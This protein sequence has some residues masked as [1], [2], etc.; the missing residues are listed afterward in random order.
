MQR[1]FSRGLSG[2]V[3]EIEPKRL[4]PTVENKAGT[5]LEVKR[6]GVG[7]LPAGAYGL[8]YVFFSPDG[9]KTFIDTAGEGGMTMLA[10]VAY[11]Y[12]AS[13]WRATKM[14]EAPLMVTEEDQ[15]T[16]MDSW[17]ADHDLAEVLAQPSPDFDMGEMLEITSHYLDNTGGC[18]WVMDK[19]SQ[20]IPRRMMPFS[21][22]EFLPQRGIDIDTGQPRL[23]ANFIVQTMEGPQ[24]KQARDVCF[25]RDTTGGTGFSIGGQGVSAWGRGRC[26][27]DIAMSWLALG[28]KAQN[29]IRALMANSVWPSI[30]VSPDKD[31]EPSKDDLDRYKDDLRKYGRNKQGEPFVALGGAAVTQIAS[32]LKDLVP[33]EVLDRVESVVA[34]VSGVPAI[35]LQ[36]EVGL[37]NAPWSHMVQARR[38]A[39]EDTIAPGWRRLERVITKQILRPMDDDPTHHIKFDK[40]TVD[41]LKRDQ[42]ES[43]QI[44]TMMGDQASLNERR[45]VMGLEPSDDPKADDIPELTKPSILDVLAAQ[46]PKPL[47]D[48]GNAPPPKGPGTGA[49]AENGPPDPKARRNALELKFKGPA[50]VNAFRHE[51]IPAWKITA[52]GLLHKDADEIAQLVDALITDSVHKSMESKARGKSRAMDAVHRYLQG[53]SKTAW[54]KAFQ[55][56]YTRAS[57]RAGSVIASTMDINFNLINANLLS[58]A[59]ENTADMITNISSTTESLVSDIIQGGLDAGQSSKEIARLLTEATGFSQTRANLI[60]RT[61]TTKAFNGAPTEALQDYGLSSGR[62]FTKTWSG[63]LD[64]RERDE[65]VEMEGE[66]VAIDDVFSNGSDYPDEPNCRCTVIFSEEET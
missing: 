26:R 35:V 32:K 21:Y 20:G 62:T 38:M 22:N 18:L 52:Q 5:A 56:M 60:A 14:A 23:Y 30:V 42:L 28:D 59:K 50:L 49:G 10:F 39:Y 1:F 48:P 17:I 9:G 51:A 65:H 27:L 2:P 55:P 4:L 7:D 37:K 13:R 31:W 19:D 6:S 3:Q 34:A 40:T 43:A 15:E 47:A 45:V 41:S 53:D 58:F 16:G 66:T 64:D 63:V 12:V 8:N 25:F 33:T 36:F 57:Q 46:K 24:T 29:T 11:W 44:A 54:T 61:E